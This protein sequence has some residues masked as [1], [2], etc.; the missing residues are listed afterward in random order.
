MKVYQ[1]KRRDKTRGPEITR[2]TKK[3]Y[4]SK[5]DKIRHTKARGA[6]NN[7]ERLRTIEQITKH[8]PEIAKKVD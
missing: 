7:N 5:R 1:S 6:N 4:Q 3:G 8:I 2:G